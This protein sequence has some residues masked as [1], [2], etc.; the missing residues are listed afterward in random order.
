MNKINDEMRKKE[1]GLTLAEKIEKLIEKVKK[2]EVIS[3]IDDAFY[4]EQNEG[5]VVYYVRRTNL[6]REDGRTLNI[7]DEIELAEKKKAEA[8]AIEEAR[9]MEYEEYKEKFVDHI[10]G[11]AENVRNRAEDT[12]EEMDPAAQPLSGKNVKQGKEVAQAAQSSQMNVT[13]RS[14]SHANSRGQASRHSQMR[15]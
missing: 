12:E 15:S 4:Q 14:S 8:D 7:P 9:D 1:K 10:E 5:G 3:H 6:H 2:K 11:R 13:G